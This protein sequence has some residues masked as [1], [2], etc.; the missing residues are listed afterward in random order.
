M[1]AVDTA[2]AVSAQDLAEG[3]SRAG[4]TAEDAG[5]SFNELLALITAV[6]QKT[7]RGGAVIGNAFKSIFTRLQRGTTIG[8]LQELGVAID[9]T[10]TGVQ[11]LQALSN[12]IEGISD[13]TIVSQIKELAGGVFQINVVS[14]ALKDLSSETG[15]FRD[16]ALVASTATNEAFQKNEALNKTIASQ[17]NALVVGLTSLAE[18]I[19]TITFG[20]LLENLVSIVSKFTS[21]LDKALDPEKGNSL[22]KGFFKGIGAFM[23]GPMVILFTAAFLKITKLVA[24]FAIEGL[25]S[26]FAMGTQAEKIKNIEGGIV[27]LLSRDANLRKTITS[28]TTTQAQ[29]EQAVIAAIRQENA[30]LQQQTTLMRGLARAAAARGVRGVNPMGGFMGRRGMFSHGFRAEEATA[31]MLGAGP[32]VKAH[33]GE[34]RINGQSFIMNSQEVEI[35]NF[36][37]GN[38]AVIPMYAGGNIPRYASAHKEGAAFRSMDRGAFTKKFGALAFNR[39]NRAEQ[40]GMTLQ[41]RDRRLLALKKQRNQKEEVALVN[42]SGSAMLVPNIGLTTKIPKGTRGRMK[43]KGKNMGFEYG[44]GLGVYGPKVPQAVD[45]AADPQDERL[46]KNITKG[47]TTSAANYAALLKPILGKPKPSQIRK[48][49]E[50]QGGGK[51]ALRGIVGAAFEAAVN[52]GLGISPARKVEGGD[53]D[54]KGVSGAKQQDV[55]K[56]FGVK[57]KSTTLFDYKENAGTGSQTSFAKK[58]GNEGRWSPVMRPARRGAKKKFA[59]G[60]IPR[61]ASGKSSAGKMATAGNAAAATF[62]KLQTSGMGL[63]M[64]FTSLTTGIGFVNA[65]HEKEI[66]TAETLRDKK[67]L[68]IEASDKDYFTKQRLI[69]QQEELITQMKNNPPA[70]VRLGEAAMTAAQAL[71]AIASINMLTGGGLGRAVAGSKFGKGVGGFF[72]GKGAKMKAAEKF[73]GQPNRMVK[74]QRAGQ[75]SKFMRGAGALT[76]GLGALDIYN[77]LSNDELTKHQ[78]SKGV[79]GA[80]GGMGG[81][82]GGAALGQAMIPIPIVGALIGGVVGG[83]LGG[84]AGE[85]IGGALNPEMQPMEANQHIAQAMLFAGKSGKEVLGKERVTEKRMGIDVD[86]PFLPHEDEISK[87]RQNKALGKLGRDIQTNMSKVPFDALSKM[88]AKAMAEIDAQKAQKQT[89]IEDHFDMG[90]WESIGVAAGV[91][92]PSS[93]D[94]KKIA[95]TAA[96]QKKADAAILKASDELANIMALKAGWNFKNE[97]EQRAWESKMNEAQEELRTAVLKHAETQQKLAKSQEERGVAVKKQLAAAEDEEALVKALAKGPNAIAMTTGA[98]LNT[99]SAQLETFRENKILADERL[100]EARQKA[101]LFMGDIDPDFMGPPTPNQMGETLLER[102]KMM[103]PFELAAE[104]AGNEFLSSAKKAGI[105]LLAKEK[106]ISK[107]KE[108]SQKKIDDLLNETVRS[109]TEMNNK[110][111]GGD[112]VDLEYQE[113]QGQVM[114]DLARNAAGAIETGD[115]DALRQFG[116]A[117]SDYDPESSGMNPEQLASLFGIDP[118]MWKT[119]IEAA[120]S[121]GMVGGGGEDGFRGRTNAEGQTFED[122]MK[123]NQGIDDGEEMGKLIEEQQG[124]AAA[125]EV[126]KNKWIAFSE[127]TDTADIA[128]KL[129]A[130]QEAINEGKTTTDALVKSVEKTLTASES[131]MEFIEEQRQFASSALRTMGALKKQMV[132]LERRVRGIDGEGDVDES[133]LTNPMVKE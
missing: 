63:Y 117:V 82:L 53:F 16:A 123:K 114:A 58:L 67:I 116:M 93:T 47:V 92:A 15:I 21:F 44:A 59:A 120:I 104:T 11:K 87:G 12:A 84:K 111:F 77:T 97:K 18:R 127:N 75:A 94:P 68:E 25:K 119:A 45:Q 40:T 1:V 107:L 41:D 129:K 48:M 37:G 4:S 61:Y 13:P 5:V 83:L 99:Q 33:M 50:R 80:L 23:S 131:Q 72:S 101:D 85:G 56:L 96:K 105:N 38:S 86:R 88:E 132:D 39:R 14:A 69:A 103:A 42:P 110:I 20:P 133:V 10:Q 65:A 22:I 2:F 130:T 124:L 29:K 125:L 64:G 90:F 121:A 35:P 95:E 51:G 109:L 7:A 54:V 100:G 108:D 57:N 9:A 78:K 30:L 106:E 74:A 19:G 36:A 126:A 66:A 31:Q 71:M 60:H 98:E 73:K 70:L 89:N 79:G 113:A 32:N 28:A 49:L 112:G 52:V 46:R 76:V 91:T 102:D 26:L 122:I 81:A 115:T 6:E 8:K 27:G 62:E 118:Q 34:G 3:F 43:F 24:K 17:M 128:T 55:V